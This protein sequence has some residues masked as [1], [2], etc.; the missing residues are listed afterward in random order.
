MVIVCDS[1]FCGAEF[2]FGFTTHS[3]ALLADAFHKLTDILAALI[4]LRAE[5]LYKRQSSG[6]Y[7]YGV[8]AKHVFGFTFESNYDVSGNV[9]EHSH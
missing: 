4:N 3:I 9:Q 1:V 2:Y 7:N 5:R 8:C 6:S